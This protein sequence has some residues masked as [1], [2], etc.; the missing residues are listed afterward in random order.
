MMLSGAPSTIPV[1][2]TTPFPSSGGPSLPA[3][4]GSPADCLLLLSPLK[5]RGRGRK[6]D[7][8]HS[9]IHRFPLLPRAGQGRPGE[10]E[11]TETGPSAPID[12]GKGES[13][14]RNCIAGPT[15]LVDQFCRSD[16]FKNAFSDRLHLL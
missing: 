5:E 8:T 15:W 14:M 11:E 16:E 1:T 9:L 2:D 13:L 10:K 4:T 3:A 12:H 6:G 7:T